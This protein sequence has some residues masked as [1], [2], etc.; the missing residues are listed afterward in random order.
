MTQ[1]V[2]YLALIVIAM[3][4]FS[5]AVE[6]GRKTVGSMVDL[7][8]AVLPLL[9]ALWLPLGSLASAAI[10]RPV[11]VFSVHF[12]LPGRGALFFP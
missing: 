11:I 12:L 4:S 10:F 6:L 3:H 2:V 1:S 9:L 8:L 7:I 5:I